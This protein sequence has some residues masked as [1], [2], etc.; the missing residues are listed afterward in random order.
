MK[1]YNPLPTEFKKEAS[2]TF[3]NL[4]LKKNQTVEKLNIFAIKLEKKA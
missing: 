1:K 4:K 3:A 2:D